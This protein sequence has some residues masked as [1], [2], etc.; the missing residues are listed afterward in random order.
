MTSHDIVA[1]S[2][3]GS[4]RRRRRQRRLDGDTCS[5]SAL[6]AATIVTIAIIAVMI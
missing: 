1:S 2:A 4:S 3:G 5:G 6:L